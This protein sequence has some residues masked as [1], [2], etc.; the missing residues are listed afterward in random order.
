MAKISVIIPNY[1][2]E[3]LIGETVENMLHQSLLP[4]EIIV[5]DDGST[6]HS[7]NILK[8][9]KNHITLIQQQNQGPGAAR[10]AGLKIASGD[11][12]QL[13][14]SDD[15]ISLNKLETQADA[16]IRHNADIAYSPWVKVFFKQKQIQLEDV[17]LQQREVPQ[18]YHPLSIFL[19]D[20]SVVLQQC[21]VRRDL[22]K[23][24]GF[25]RTDMWTC[26]DSDFFM[27]MLLLRPKLI[28]S[29]KSLTL[30]RLDDYGKVTGSGAS[31]VNRTED[32]TRFL[33]SA[34]E[35][36]SRYA[37]SHPAITHPSFLAN[38][39]KTKQN[40]LQQGSQK[41]E[42]QQSLAAII[43]TSSTPSLLPLYGRCLE[44]IKGLQFRLVK[45]R[46]SSSY[47]PGPLTLAQKHLISV[48][49]FS[50]RHSM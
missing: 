16:L 29:P 18:K 37:W 36:C 22:I 17:V 9:F 42:L 24:V 12:V 32:W 44:I 3:A 23:K 26:D 2:R 50:I 39:W 47:Q 35:H 43:K 45:H 8:S 33:V 27:R 19:K 13:M 25:Y 31:I 38:A 4:H 41:P 14:D 46:W 40:L 20:W 49:G 48:L 15:L 7:I 10:N 21:L 34:F 5:V 6:D 1:N 28:F 11:F 30:Y